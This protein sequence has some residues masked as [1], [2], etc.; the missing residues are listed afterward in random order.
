MFVIYFLSPFDVVFFNDTD[1]LP[2]TDY[3]Y[4][5][6]TSNIGG[7]TESAE[8]RFK[9]ESGIP[10]GVPPLEVSDIKSTEATFKWKE[11]DVAHGPI[12]KYVLQVQYL[13]LIIL[14]VIHGLLAF[15]CSLCAGN[16]RNYGW[17]IDPKLHTGTLFQL[18]CNCYCGH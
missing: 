3:D 18:R 1:L 11:P 8:E 5:I 2:Y 7:S 4:H 10:T 13:F 6:V 14:N 17:G 15:M 16:V 9:T 12:E